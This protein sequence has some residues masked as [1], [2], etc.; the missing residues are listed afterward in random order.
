MGDDVNC[1]ETNV[2]FFCNSIFL[3]KKN[4]LHIHTYRSID[5]NL[6]INPIMYCKQ[7]WAKCLD[8][9]KHMLEE[10]KKNQFQ[11]IISMR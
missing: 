7:N 3:K 4:I 8:D 11:S 1:K 6:V 2:W 9:N 5:Y 10:R